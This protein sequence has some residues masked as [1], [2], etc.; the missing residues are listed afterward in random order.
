MAADAGSVWA[1]LGPNGAGKTTTLLS[2]A[3]LLTRT[4]G[5]VSVDDVELPGAQPAAAAQSGVVLVPDDRALFGSLT[6]YENLKVAATKSGP[7]VD[8]VL[9]LF[10]ALQRRVRV[11][12]SSLSGGEQ[13]MLAVA[14]GL[15]RAPRVLLVDELSM[16]LAPKIVEELLPVLREFALTSGAVVMLV[17]Q[18]VSL[19]LEVADHAIVLVHGE[20]VINESTAALA[21]DFDRLRDAY[22]GNV[23]T[24]R[25]P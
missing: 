16:G 19:A 23:G 15:I 20:I 10:P 1:L 9:G 13:Q 25:S 8:A 18:H 5:S 24:V 12:A 3:G 14:R 22:L 21:T 7:D 17:E 2:L 11:A 6:T 4:G